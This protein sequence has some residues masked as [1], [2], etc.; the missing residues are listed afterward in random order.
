MLGPQNGTCGTL[1]KVLK[2]QRL[3]V[4]VLDKRPTQNW[5]QTLFR[6]WDIDSHLKATKIYCIASLKLKIVEFTFAHAQ[7][8]GQR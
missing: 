2:L 8:C 7:M 4:G 6:V 5:M 1:L 3:C